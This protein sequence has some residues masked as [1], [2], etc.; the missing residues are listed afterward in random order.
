MDETDFIKFIKELLKKAL[1]S[2]GNYCFH[3]VS[4]TS[5]FAKSANSW[6]TETLTM[7]VQ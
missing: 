1:E 6:L 4:S 2:E 7:H 5:Q 3:R